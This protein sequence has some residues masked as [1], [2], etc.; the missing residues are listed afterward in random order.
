MNTIAMHMADGLIS[1]N[2]GFVF[3]ILI[4]AMMGYSL[5]KMSET[6]DEKKIPMM[7][8]MGAFI[9]AAQMINFTIP[10]TGSSGHICGA[11]LLCLIIGQYPAFLSICCVLIIQCFF[12]GDGGMLAL[13]C[14]IFNMGLIPCFL[15]YPLITKK[16]LSSGINKKTIALG[17]ML[18]CVIGLELG[19]LGVVLETTM[20]GITALP[21]STFAILM[22]PIHAIIGLIEGLIT[23][24]VGLYVYKNTPDILKE[25]LTSKTSLIGHWNKSF[26]IFM[27]AALIIAGGL[28][29]FAST[30][31][32]G[33]EWSI[34]KITGTT[35]I[36]T[37]GKM[38]SAIDDIQ[39]ATSFFSNYEIGGKNSLVGGSM[40]GIIGTCATLILAGGIGYVITRK[41]KHE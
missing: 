10:G 21:F 27:L 28:S 9:F 4:I 1:V 30:N 26:K 31:P 2:V 33:L 41:K 39:K 38:K 19:A 22:L 5:K 20:S 23:S 32:D 6:K 36:Q 17:S 24:A 35:E 29:V 15:A 18:G 13:G 25:A 11:I 12:F 14:N 8:V 37:H 40:A 7:A 16:I 34:A 3:L